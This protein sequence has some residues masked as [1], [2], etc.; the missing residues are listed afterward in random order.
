MKRRAPAGA[1]RSS[2]CF[3]RAENFRARWAGAERQG[4][5]SRRRGARFWRW[6]RLALA[7]HGFDAGQSSVQVGAFALL[8]IGIA[9]R[10]AQRLA[11]MF[12]RARGQ[13][14]Q[15]VVIEDR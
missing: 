5:P 7:Q 15:G 6:R 9:E 10:L 8:Q 2:A 13:P 12:E 1:A 14:V 3:E 11:K 4:A